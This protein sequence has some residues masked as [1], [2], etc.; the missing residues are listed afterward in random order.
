MADLDRLLALEPANSAA[1]QLARAVVS[2]EAAAAGAAARLSESRSKSSTPD[3]I[4]L[5]AVTGQASPEGKAEVALQHLCAAPSVEAF[6][7][8][9][10]VVA[11][12]LQH[13]SATASFAFSNGVSAVTCAQHA[14]PFAAAGLLR[15]LLR[16]SGSSPRSRLHLLQ[17]LAKPGVAAAWFKRSA[18]SASPAGDWPMAGVGLYGSVMHYYAHGEG[19]ATGHAAAAAAA[20]PSRSTTDQ[21]DPEVDALVSLRRFSIPALVSVL[22]APP[23]PRARLAAL[24][25]ISATLASPGEAEVFLATGALRALVAATSAVDDLGEASPAPAATPPNRG[26]TPPVRPEAIPRAAQ[27]ALATLLQ[28][29]RHAAGQSG[30][31]IQERV[32]GML[33]SQCQHAL[34]SLSGVNGEQGGSA[35][36]L[37]Q[38]EEKDEAVKQAVAADQKAFER[39]ERRRLAEAKKADAQSPQPSQSSSSSG[40]PE[41]KAA[42][43]SDAVVEAVQDGA[44]GSS[45]DPRLSQ[46]REREDKRVQAL[47][48]ASAAASRDASKRVDALEAERALKLLH[49]A[50]LTHPD[51][52]LSLLQRASFKT[53]L[54]AAGQS[55]R[56]PTQVAMADLVS[57]VV[58]DKEGGGDSIVSQGLL[59]LLGEL[60]AART[61]SLR[62]AATVALAKLTS[63]SMVSK[64]G[65]G[66]NGLPAGAAAGGDSDAAAQAEATAAQGK[67]KQE[68]LASVYMATAG[69]LASAAELLPQLAAAGSSDDVQE[70]ALAETGGGVGSANSA[71]TTL[72]GAGA[73]V[74]RAIESLSVI[75]GHTSVKH[76]IMQDSSTLR[77]VMQLLHALGH[78]VAVPPSRAEALGASPPPKQA[79]SAAGSKAGMDLATQFAALCGGS[80]TLLGAAYIMYAL[81]TSVDEQRTAALAQMELDPETWEKFQQLTST[82]G[83]GI[84]EPDPPEA[85]LARVKALVAMEGTV[86]DA[87]CA[88]A[89][90]ATGAGGVGGAARVSRPLTVVGVLQGLHGMV[91]QLAQAAG[92]DKAEEG[93]PRAKG[94]RAPRSMAGRSI[95]VNELL[96]RCAL[97]L[98]AP[99]EKALRGRL[100]QLGSVGLL[101]HLA[102]GRKNTHTGQVQAAQALARLLISTNPG[103]LPESQLHDCIAPLVVLSRVLDAGPANMAKKGQS[104]GAAQG[105]S[106]D[107]HTGS[108]SLQRFE[109]CLA[110]TNLASHGATTQRILIAAGAL[111]SLESL[112]FDRNAMV[113][114]AATEGITNLATTD[115]GRAVITQRSLALWCALASA[116]WED[117]VTSVAAAGGLA[118]ATSTQ[119]D[120]SE[121]EVKSQGIQWVASQSA[122]DGN[123]VG[124]FDAGRVAARAVLAGDGVKAMASA[125]LSGITDLQH[126]ALVVLRNL[127]Y[128]PGGAVALSQPVTIDVGFAQG[129]DDDA[130]GAADSGNGER[131]G[132]AAAPTETT[133]PQ[134][135]VEVVPVALLAAMAQGAELPSWSELKKEEQAGDDPKGTVATTSPVLRQ[136]ADTICTVV[137]E[138]LEQD[139]N[140]AGYES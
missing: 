53:L 109:A 97:G 122:A 44:A 88:A 113:R 60:A 27:S 33:L 35:W 133:G 25:A 128:V 70:G 40:A 30:D 24:E 132:A 47:Q 90:A 10:P 92:S 31:A 43:D 48:A 96:A 80:P 56:T 46:L 136:L 81:V 1:T 129:E 49:T 93:Q 65:V 13:S 12:T 124:L 111:S 104:A 137:K 23:T 64:P 62:S 140:P 74:A 34:R 50:F 11:G 120:V 105:S 78:G 28:H 89:D 42:D 82:G 29:L 116:Y 15:L 134:S 86:R 94:S 123:E 126:R 17:S 9:A 59:A 102:E 75:V 69:L 18:S 71:S 22:K 119:Y 108:V 91:E 2:G 55:A 66:L 52:A 16:G 21:S 26:S 67:A 3:S 135:T 32:R 68:A 84:D 121:R 131:K 37:A 138:Q 72:P 19:A 61:L 112:Q 20:A 76:A 117:E 54:L 45:S 98:T 100:V 127:L 87:A 130:D 57:V 51:A 118:M 36:D 79:A 4:A 101:L 114:R 7:A 41:S 95:M 125:L 115:A 38:E 139:N 5:A 99:Q 6:K 14:E 107:A 39:A 106:F 110:L 63:G 103:L 58:G 73:V 8:I 83:G 85:V 77:A